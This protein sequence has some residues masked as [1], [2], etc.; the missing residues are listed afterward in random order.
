MSKNALKIYGI[1][2]LIALIISFVV[3]IAGLIIVSSTANIYGWNLNTGTVQQMALGLMLLGMGLGAVMGLSFMGTHMAMQNMPR[4]S[5][6]GT[7]NMFGAN[8]CRKCGEKLTISTPQSTPQYSSRWQC[9]SCGTI[10]VIGANF[11]IRCGK[12]LQEVV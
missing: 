6:C 12:K 7:R 3:C 5:R 4:C 9:S 2:G 1:G 11:C 8:F 10:N